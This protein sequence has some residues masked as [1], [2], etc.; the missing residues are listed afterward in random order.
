MI[1]KSNMNIDVLYKKHSLSGWSTCLT[2]MHLKTS[3]PQNKQTK[4]KSK[5]KLKV[6]D[7]P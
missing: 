4:K 2:F 6:T 1:I 3:K 7:K 5:T